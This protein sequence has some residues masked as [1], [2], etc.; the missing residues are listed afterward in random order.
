[1][2]TWICPQCGRE[3]PPAYNE[4]PDCAARIAAGSAPPGAASSPQDPL[5]PAAPP[6]TAPPKDAPPAFQPQPASPRGG[7]HLPTWLMAMLFALG[8]VV[9]GG[10]GFWF[11]GHSSQQGCCTV[12][13]R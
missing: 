1:M 9:V 3:V 13:N 4:C 11:L 12:A 5:A 10:G 2:F 6:A 8:F 7:T